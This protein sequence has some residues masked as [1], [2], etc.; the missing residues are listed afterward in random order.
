MQ[1]YLFILA[2]FFAV[3]CSTTKKDVSKD[4][5][6]IHYDQGTQDLLAANYTQA[7]S[8]LITAAKL[9]GKNPEIHNNLGM[10]YYFKGEKDQAFAHIKKALEIDPTLT[11]ARVNLASLLFERGDLVGAEKHYLH[12]LKDVTYEKH[13]RT[14]YNLALI[15]L[16]RNNTEKS[17]AH[18]MSAIK[19]NKDYCP[20]WMQLGELDYKN[21]RF[22]DA[23]KN[24]REAR[25]GVCV[26]SPAP[27]YWLA[28]TEIELGDYLGARMKLDEIETKFSKTP[29]GSLAQQKLTEITLL[30]NRSES[31]KS[32]N[33]KPT[34]NST[35]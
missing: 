10:A 34:I 28:L 32:K 4:Q 21:R 18:L 6:Q 20:A 12:A 2:I 9:D 7:V 8:H 11:D 17:R 31:M 25:M 27:L 23:H 13:S 24:F 22:K 29:Y 16:K 30:E 26:N 33:Q 35:F 14:Y 19:E 1:N 5:A 3:S 15:E